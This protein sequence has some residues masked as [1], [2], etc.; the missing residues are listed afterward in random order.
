MHIISRSEAATR[1][2]EALGIDGICSLPL[3][4]A[5]PEILPDDDLPRLVILEPAD[6]SVADLSD[7]NPPFSQEERL[8]FHT[9]TFKRL[10]DSVLRLARRLDRL[11]A[12]MTLL[13][14]YEVRLAAARRK[15]GIDKRST[16]RARVSV[17]GVRSLDPVVP[18]DRWFIDQVVLA[19]GEPFSRPFR[20]A[21]IPGGR[22][23]E[24]VREPDVLVVAV[25]GQ[26]PHETRRQIEER[27]S[28]FQNTRLLFPEPDW[29]AAAGPTV[30]AGVHYLLEEL[31]P[32]PQGSPPEG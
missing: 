4:T 27:G 23:P 12:A 6:L 10:L 22:A 9:D 25:P 17:A 2:A 3:S 1:W 13:A 26:T 28:G 29:F 18:L 30:Y 31:H 32:Y 24:D 5:L 11:E 8:I 19:G 14:D 21:A 20:D 7:V 15:Y 16:D